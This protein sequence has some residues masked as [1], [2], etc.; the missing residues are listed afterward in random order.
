MSFWRAE[1][2]LEKLPDLIDPPDREAVDC[3]AY[4]LHVGNEIYVSPDQGVNNPN[5]HTKKIL[6]DGEGF[7][8]PPGQFAFLMTIE[9]VSVPNDAL[10]FLSIKARTKFSGL[11]NISGF[12]VDPGYR[13]KLLFSVLNAGPRPLHLQQGQAL[14]LIWYADLDGST[15]YNKQNRGFDGIEPEMIN[16]ISGEIL[17]LQSLSDKQHALEKELAKLNTSATFLFRL[18]IVVIVLI[19]TPIIGWLW[20]KLQAWLGIGA[21]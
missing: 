16:R 17:S 13:G 4:T 1:T 18:A 19:A 3:A 7:T 10:A 6:A 15:E 9:T 21:S 14:F 20:P 11:I 5:R 8:I 2:L 12:H